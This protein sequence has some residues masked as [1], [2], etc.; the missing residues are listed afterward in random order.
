MRLL[1]MIYLFN[2]YLV[3]FNFR[4]NDVCVVVNVF[5][6]LSKIFEWKK[7]IGI[8]ICVNIDVDCFEFD[9]FDVFL[10]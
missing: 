8:I 6:I 9:L 7:K 2:W 1:E 5:V 4:F 10:R 3:I